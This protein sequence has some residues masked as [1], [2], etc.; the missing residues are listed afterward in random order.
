MSAT[1]EHRTDRAGS[2]EPMAHRSV[3]SATVEPARLVRSLSR[4]W[5]PR[6]QPLDLFALAI[7]VL[8]A[9]LPA[10]ALFDLIAGSRGT[11]ALTLARSAPILFVVLIVALLE[12]FRPGSM[13][14]K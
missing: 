8:G 4:F 14:G 2:L 5:K 12:A 11:I 1:H 7:V 3:T 9:T 10:C 6:G 13:T